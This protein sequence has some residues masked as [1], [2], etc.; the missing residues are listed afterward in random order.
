MK[1]IIDGKVY[2][3]I[4]ATAVADWWNRVSQSDFSYCEETLY[5][6]RKGAFFIAG[7]GGPMTKWSEPCGNNAVS[8]GSGIIPMNKA[9]ALE[10]CEQ[11]DIDADI[12]ENYFHVEEA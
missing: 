8:G 3:T 7:T 10:W 12:I 11:H 5:R 4:T 6:T 1:K 2:N 9:E